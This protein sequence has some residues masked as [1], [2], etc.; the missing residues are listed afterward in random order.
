MR[1]PLSCFLSPQAGRK[2]GRSLEGVLFLEL[3]GPAHGISY[4]QFAPSLPRA[5]AGNEFSKHISY[6]G[7][8]LSL[9]YSFIYFFLPL[10]GRMNRISARIEHWSIKLCSCTLMGGKELTALCSLLFFTLQLSVALS[11]VSLAA[12]K[13]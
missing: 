6:L 12:N 2:R 9:F 11:K 7:L 4:R 5:Q 10:S 13:Q 3:G 8:W 1:L